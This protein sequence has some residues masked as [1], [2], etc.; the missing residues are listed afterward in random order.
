MQ[1]EGKKKP[2]F[3]KRNRGQLESSSHPDPLAQRVTKV[4]LSPV[5]FSLFRIVFR[6]PTAGLSAFA[7]REA[8]SKSAGAFVSPDLSFNRLTPGTVPYVRP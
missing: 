1:L 5:V 2:C 3:F 8:C 6:R 7:E 4:S